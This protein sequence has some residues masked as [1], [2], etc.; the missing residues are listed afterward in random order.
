MEE[1]PEASRCPVCNG[2]VAASDARPCPRCDTPHHA[3]CWDYV[4]DCAIFGC[5]PALP[6]GAGSLPVAR[7]E[8]REIASLARW[9]TGLFRVHWWGFLAM[10]LPFAWMPVVGVLSYLLGWDLLPSLVPLAM[11]AGACTYFLLLIP[12]LGTKWALENRLGVALQPPRQGTTDLLDSMEMSRS[13]G[14]LLTTVQHGPTVYLAILLTVLVL[15]GGMLPVFWS[16]FAL[17]LLLGARYATRQR[18]V[19]IEALQNRLLASLKEK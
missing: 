8:R 1:A 13:G 3:E 11:L 12:L 15:G 2:E 7:G 14:L 9:Y 17:P 19:M 5:R 10:A 4:G 18:V 16:L 6:G